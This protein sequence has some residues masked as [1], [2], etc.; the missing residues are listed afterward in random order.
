MVFL[1]SSLSIFIRSSCYEVFSSSSSLNRQSPSSFLQLVES[2]QQDRIHS[3]SLFHSISTCI[4]CLSTLLY[5]AFSFSSVVYH[6]LQNM[7]ESVR[8]L[9]FTDLR[10][11]HIL[12]LLCCYCYYHETVDY[13]L[14][15]N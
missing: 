2:F 1:L 4:F 15:F 13:Y 8:V 11:E 14:L 10:I 3:E 12:L 6:I 7:T 9:G 5:L